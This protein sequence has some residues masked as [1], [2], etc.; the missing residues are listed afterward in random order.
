MHAPSQTCI[1]S[2]QMTDN[3]CEIE[4]TA[5]TH[6]ACAPRNSG[7]LLTEFAAAYPSVN[8]S[9][10]FSVLEN[11]GLPD[12]LC[13]FLRS[14]HRDSITHVEF[15]GAKRGQFFHGKRS[16][17]RLSCEWLSVCNVL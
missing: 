7:V 3:I 13:R 12:F 2:G 6:V 9:W 5:L 10:I 17:T 14:I 4:T 11:N 1:S 15:A 8:H 16:T